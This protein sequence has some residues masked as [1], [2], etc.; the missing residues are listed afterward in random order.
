MKKIIF[1]ITITA[2]VLIGCRSRQQCMVDD[3]KYDI[4]WELFCET[5]GYAPDNHSES[6]TNEYL[7]AWIGTTEEETAFET[8]GIQLY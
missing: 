6:V 7:D 2:T 4:S 5:R 1:S 3:R 8:A